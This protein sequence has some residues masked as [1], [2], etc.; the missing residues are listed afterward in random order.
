MEVEQRLRTTDDLRIRYDTLFWIKH[1]QILASEIRLRLVED[2]RSIAT[3][4]TKIL[5]KGEKTDETNS[6]I[7]FFHSQPSLTD[8][9]KPFHCLQ[10]AHN[11]ILEKP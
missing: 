10:V 8:K 2:V 7:I 1:R 5:D 6:A 11:D 3:T 4:T 9:M